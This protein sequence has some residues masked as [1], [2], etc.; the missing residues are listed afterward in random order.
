M[1]FLWITTGVTSTTPISYVDNIIE[2]GNSGLNSVYHEHNVAPHT[3]SLFVNLTWDDP[4]TKLVLTIHKP[5]GSVY[6]TYYPDGGPGA[7][8]TQIALFINKSIGLESGTWG[9]LIDY[10]EGKAKT[11][12]RI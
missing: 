1:I 12:Y 11:N 4:A 5:D 7:Y 10:A 2:P 6:G 9:Y 8:K 3:I